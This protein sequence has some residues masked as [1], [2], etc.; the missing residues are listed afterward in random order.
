MMVS[1]L[2][3]RSLRVGYRSD[4]GV[5][6][7][8]DGLNFSVGEGEIFG[9]VGESG[10]GKSTLG[11]SL[12]K[13]FPPES[14][15]EG[16]IVFEGEDILRLDEEKIRR[17]R[18]RKIAMVFQDPMANLD[19]LM[20]I[21]DQFIE[22]LGVHLRLSKRD[23]LRMATSGLEA[24]GLPLENLAL[25]P[26]ELSH[27]SLG[28]VAL[29][30]AL[31]LSPKL[32]VIDD[33]ISSLDATAQAELLKVI[34]SLRCGSA[35]T[36]LIMTQ[37]PRTLAQLTDSTM[38]MYAGEVVEV[39]LTGDLLSTPLHP[40]SKSLVRSAS[41]RGAGYRTPCS[42]DGR[43]SSPLNPPNGC[44]FYPRCFESMDICSMRQ[45]NMVKLSRSRFV[46]CWKYYG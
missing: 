40:Y 34:A 44:K 2:E 27:L 39:A 35:I 43:A 38:V 14:R 42:I 22:L 21:R 32:L 1:L 45:P 9:V 23:A 30:M 6:W 29:A 36:L 4:G 26:F 16:E 31:V 17:L 7:A 15:V 12:L 20:K 11:L 13:L 33:L 10:C 25:Y 46:K 24:V 37:N 41:D 28:K 3:V 8:I 19:P 18:G 5:S